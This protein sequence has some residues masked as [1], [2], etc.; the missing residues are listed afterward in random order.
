MAIQVKW[1]VI[2]HYIS[3]R[4]TPQL[5]WPLDPRTSRFEEPSTGR[6][7]PALPAFTLTCG[8]TDDTLLTR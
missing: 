5:N 6:R 7:R 4:R 3:R 2:Y 1:A 8:A